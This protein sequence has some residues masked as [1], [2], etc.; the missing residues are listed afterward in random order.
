MGANNTA[1]T[2]STGRYSLLGHRCQ[3]IVG[4]ADNNTIKINLIGPGVKFQSC[5]VVEI[6]T[7][8]DIGGSVERSMVGLSLICS[9]SS[10]LNG[11]L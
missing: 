10:L 8:V 4:N 3:G 7:G 1:T 2:S 9:T 6:G 5:G 11:R